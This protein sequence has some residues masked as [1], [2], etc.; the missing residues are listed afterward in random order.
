MASDR[1]EKA[2]PKRREEAR[3]RGQVARSME[4]NTGAGLLA[5]FTL[6]AV[7]G[8]GMFAALAAVMSEG[9][10]GAGT[11]GP[12]TPEAAWSIIMDTGRT[13]MRVV[14][15]FAIGCA[16]VG[17]LASAIQVRP[18][19]LLS[20]L[21]PRFSAV[22]PKSGIKR[23]FSLRSL[24]R[25]VKDLLKIGIVAAVTWWVLRGEMD[26][27]VLLTGARPETS[28]AVTA[29][30]V[31]HVGFAVAAAY[32][33]MALA[34]VVYERWQH[35]RDMRMSKDDVKREARDGDLSPEIRA[36]MKRRQR[37]MAVRRMMSAVPEADVVITNPTHYAV[38]LRYAR[39]LPA[40]QVVAK[41]ADQVALRIIA[42]AREHGVEVVQDPPLA[43]SL[44]AAA[45]VGQFIP[46]EAF[47]AVA[48]ILAAVYRVTGREPAHA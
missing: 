39:S 18:G 40:P 8:G 12:I 45:E 47:A 14:A 29:G 37:E 9:L 31:M 26:E 1:T 28:M 44:H 7:F 13:A 15:P 27:L 33:V 10:A 3:S 11:T 36:Q 21:T 42:T 46:A 19:L 2:T 6:L 43:R 16:I 5:V 25:L 32:I 4:L 23:L 35:E 41:G 34:D 30:A 22:S 48:E 24:V 17:A 20:V 38:A